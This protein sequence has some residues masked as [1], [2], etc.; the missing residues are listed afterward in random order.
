ML[1]SKQK[2]K[3]SNHSLFLRLI[4]LIGMVN[5]VLVLSLIFVSISL[6][7]WFYW[8]NN[9]L[10]DLGVAEGIVGNLFNST[11]IIGGILLGLFA[12]GIHYFIMQD[13]KSK[14]SFKIIGLFGTLILI[15]DSASLCAIGIFP[16]S[17]QP[18]H[19][20]ASITFFVLLPISLFLLG[21]GTIKID[22]HFPKYWG[23]LTITLGIIAAVI[24][25]FPTEGY[26]IPEIVSGF[27]LAIWSFILGL[28]LFQQKKTI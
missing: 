20:I 4:G 10:S 7:P 28:K 5:P 24:W 26:A 9:A 12:I 22:K 19:N 16:E 1:K 8:G 25:A 6:S 3:K 15:A 2:N 18:T 27:S 14:K 11:L 21:F 17:I 13:Q 23:V